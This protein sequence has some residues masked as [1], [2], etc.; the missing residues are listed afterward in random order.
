MLVDKDAKSCSG[1]LTRGEPERGHL[2]QSPPLLLGEPLQVDKDLVHLF[3]VHL[4][5]VFVAAHQLDEDLLKG[6][7]LLHGVCHSEEAVLSLTDIFAIVLDDPAWG[8]ET[9]G[10]QDLDKVNSVAT[11]VELLAG[12]VEIF[13]QRLKVFTG[14]FETLD[15]GI[16]KS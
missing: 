6:S 10:N 15:N 8:Q 16:A 13:A 2:S 12:G 5:E 1:N 11:I 7:D 14:T 4:L 9:P 3:F